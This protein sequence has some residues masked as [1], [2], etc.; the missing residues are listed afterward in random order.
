MAREVFKRHEAHAV[1]MDCP[2]WRNRD[3]VRA[4]A[5][6]HADTLSHRVDYSIKRAIRIVGRD[7]AA[8]L[9]VS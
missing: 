4:Q 9:E 2:W 3:E 5:E 8:P 6:R 7:V 1:C